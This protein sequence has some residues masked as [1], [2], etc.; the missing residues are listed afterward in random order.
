MLKTFHK[1]RQMTS[2]A[3][4]WSTNAITPSGKESHQNDQAQFTLGEA[5]LAV[6]SNR[7]IQARFPLMNSCL[8]LLTIFFPF[9]CLEIILRISCSIIFLGTEV[10]MAGLQF[11]SSSCLPFL[12]TGLILAFLQSS[13][14]SLVLHDLSK[15]TKNVIWICNPVS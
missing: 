4:H 1:S 6:L 14:T 2:V 15:M 10:R 13:G 11:P 7:L 9:T 12:K 8:V 5:I 3:P